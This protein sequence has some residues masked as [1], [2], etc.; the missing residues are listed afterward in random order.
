MSKWSQAMEEL[1]RKV[2][3]IVETLDDALRPPPELVP[4]PVDREPRRR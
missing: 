1:R 3:E 2:R 4:V